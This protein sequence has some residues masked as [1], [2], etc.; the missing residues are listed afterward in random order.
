MGNS[1]KDHFSGH[2]E[3]YAAARPTYPEELFLWIAGLPKERKVAWD[4]ATGNGQAA[5][6]L[7][8]HFSRV[9]AT[10][11]SE[12]QIESAPDTPGITFRTEKAESPSLG[13]STVDLVTVA[14]GAHWFDLE[15]FFVSVDRVLKPYGI[16]ALWCYEKCTINEEV[17][18]LIESYYQSL[19]P[20]WPPERKL[21]EEGYSAIRFPYEETIAPAF[22][23]SISWTAS[24]ML[25]YLES[26]SA[27]QKAT[28]ALKLDPLEEIR[29]ELLRRWGNC[30][31]E[32]IWPVSMR[33][34]PKPG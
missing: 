34:G 2:S 1:F 13:D 12:N 17:D 14:Q 21:V 15:R 11:A 25:A 19:D 22:Q 26:W 16:L 10:D 32:V 29:H 27:T 9:I 28:A 6:A 20:Y 5:I 3:L 23:M 33:V 31:Q 18:K 8:H 7:S 24:Q 30:D 4:V